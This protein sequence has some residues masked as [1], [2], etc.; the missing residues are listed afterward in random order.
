VNERF[1]FR[2]QIVVEMKVHMT[3]MFLSEVQDKPDVSLG[4]LR[5]WFDVW[6]RA[7]HSNAQRFNSLNEKTVVTAWFGSLRGVK[8]RLLRES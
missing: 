7:H 4:L 1:R 5:G 6:G 8:K 2:V 3:S